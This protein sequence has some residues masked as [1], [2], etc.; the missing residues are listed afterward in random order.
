MESRFLDG[1]P[2]ILS[3]AANGKSFTKGL[4]HGPF[5]VVETRDVPASLQRRVGHSQ[6]LR[7]AKTVDGK[8]LYYNRKTQRWE[9]P[10]SSS[11]RD[12]VENPPF[13]SGKYFQ[14]A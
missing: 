2:I 14:S 5:I 12:D 9:R 4:G 7:V 8:T 10:M 6:W 11:F 13:F 1:D 3:N